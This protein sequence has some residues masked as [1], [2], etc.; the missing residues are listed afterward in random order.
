M[1]RTATL[2]VRIPERTR[3][4]LTHL[5]SESDKSENA[6]AAEAIREFVETQEWQINA[7]REGIKAADA[8]RLTPYAEVRK[9][10]E[11]RRTAL[12]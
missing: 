3:Q 8:G 9:R 10:W 6:L 2:T 4:K 11:S 12:A 1:A 7:I 5:A